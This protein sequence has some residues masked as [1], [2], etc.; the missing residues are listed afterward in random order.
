MKRLI[1]IAAV[2][3]TLSFLIPASSASASDHS[4]RGHGHQTHQR[5]H[6]N[7]YHGRYG[8]GSRYRPVV[9]RPYSSNYRYRSG[10]SSRPYGY[11]PSR[12]HGHYPSYGNRS[13]VHLDINGVHILGRHHH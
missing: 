12:H 4:R 10:Y 2:A 7:S 5:H 3:A 6:G 11:R 9:I 1:A 13:G 8:F